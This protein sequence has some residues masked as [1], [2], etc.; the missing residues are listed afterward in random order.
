MHRVSGGVDVSSDAGIDDVLSGLENDLGGTAGGT[1]DDDHDDDE[2]GVLTLNAPVDVRTLPTDKNLR[3]SAFVERLQS[4]KR[5]REAAVKEE[6][7]R[8]LAA[9]TEEERV[10][11]TCLSEVPVPTSCL[12]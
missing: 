6:E 10:C 4:E 7:A 5:L 3:N 1:D 8:L 9:M 2:P 12:W 11:L